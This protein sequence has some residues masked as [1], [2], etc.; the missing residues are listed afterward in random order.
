MKRPCRQLSP[1]AG[2]CSLVAFSACGTSEPLPGEEDLTSVVSEV[3]A[4]AV[5]ISQ[6]ID[7][8]I[9][10]SETAAAGI[11][12]TPVVAVAYNLVDS[13]HIPRTGQRCRGYAMLG[14]SYF[15]NGSWRRTHIPVPSIGIASLRYR[16]VSGTAFRR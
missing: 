14:L 4:G 16:P 8:S 11:P 10:E 5:D 9:V 2:W 6:G 3:V 13:G 1:L 15:T 7:Q 12:G